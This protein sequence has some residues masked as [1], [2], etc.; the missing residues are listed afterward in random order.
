MACGLVNPNAVTMAMAS[1]GGPVVV[2]VGLGVGGTKALE[3][4]D[5][6]YK[7]LCQYI[8]IASLVPRPSS[9][10]YPKIK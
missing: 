3:K 7:K 1:S 9:T 10:P 2:V 6:W 8:Y 5:S 4:S